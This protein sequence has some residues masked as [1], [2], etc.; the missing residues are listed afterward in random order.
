MVGCLVGWLA[1]RFGSDQ[2]GWCVLTKSANPRL[3]GLVELVGWL[4]GW[5]VGRLV[6][7]LAGCLADWLVGTLTERFI[8]LFGYVVESTVGWSDGRMLGRAWR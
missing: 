2:A 1:G 7:W 5:L 3:V 8:S 6:G 4:V